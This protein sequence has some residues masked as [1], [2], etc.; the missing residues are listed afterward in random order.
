MEPYITGPVTPSG[1]VM[2]GEAEG[3]SCSSGSFFSTG[4]Q[5]HPQ[6]APESPSGRTSFWIQERSGKG[7]FKGGGPKA[8]LVTKGPCRSSHRVGRQGERTHQVS[9][10]VAFQGNVIVSF[11]K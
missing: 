2:L 6:M 4:R 8:A 11:I 3:A 10:Q 5:G 7:L 1:D 9:S